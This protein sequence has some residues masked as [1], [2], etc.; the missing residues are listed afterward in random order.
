MSATNV[1]F[2]IAS[3]V[4]AALAFK[5]DTGVTSAALAGSVNADPTFVRKMISKLVKAGLITTTRGRGGACILARPA[6]EITLLDIYH[7]SHVPLTFSIH[8]YPVEEECLTSLCIKGLLAD[9]LHSAQHEFE[10]S[11]EKY[12]LSDIAAGIQKPQ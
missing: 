11:L 1:Q 3:H 2:S 5:H 9:V 10:K 7:A 8:D 4:M 6:K 12:S